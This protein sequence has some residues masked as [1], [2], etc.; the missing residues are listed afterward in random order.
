MPPIKK[1]KHGNS[2]RPLPDA[3][4]KPQKRH[5]GNRRRIEEKPV[6][7][8]APKKK[9]TRERR[10]VRVPKGVA[11]SF[12]ALLL[13]TAIVCS[14]LAA[15]FFCYRAARSFCITSDYFNVTEVN[16]EGVKRSSVLPLLADAG[17]EKGRNSL[18]VNIHDL[19]KK[20]M[21]DPWIS[22]ISVR[23]ELPGRFVIKVEEREPRFCA[24]KNGVLYY[25]NGKGELISPVTK[26][27]FT[28]LPI[29]EI[30]P[31]GEE[32]LP[33][34]ADFLEAFGYA[35]FPFDASQ[36][37]WIKVSA[38]SGFELYWESRHLRLCI[39]AENWKANLKMMA[40]VVTDIEKRRESYSVT[41]IRAADGQ[42]WTKSGD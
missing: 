21:N 12:F 42:V 30:G 7:P 35:G 39:G 38:G 34:V 4:Q 36:I 28:S 19:E 32:S 25:V 37:S 6:Q 26:T 20:L 8:P 31:G 5:S 24:R 17:L 33:L 9:K 40:T 10:P 1:K 11:R 29:L 3:V 14:V 16:I 22:S 2:L 13:S 15:G 18:L 27:N 41:E 23:R